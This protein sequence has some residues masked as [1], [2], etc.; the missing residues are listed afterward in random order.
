[1]FLSL[2]ERFPPLK[3]QQNFPM[4]YKVVVCLTSSCHPTWRPSYGCY[5]SNVVVQNLYRI[6]SS[7]DKQRIYT[8]A[9]PGVN[10]VRR[11][12]KFLA[13]SRGHFVYSCRFY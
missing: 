5:A 10:K 9:K 12:I 3:T 7:A 1:M 6:E 2:S 4:A 8:S 11:I 13:V